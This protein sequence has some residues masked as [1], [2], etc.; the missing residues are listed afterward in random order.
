M[1][2][3]DPSAP[4]RMGDPVRFLNGPVCTVV[5]TDDED[6]TVCIAWWCDG[7]MLTYAWVPEGLLIHVQGVPMTT[8]PDYFGEWEDRCPQPVERRSW[9]RRVEQW[10]KQKTISRPD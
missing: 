10:F 7:P 1:I 3:E 6:N 5:A 8:D 9:A 4:F 2:D